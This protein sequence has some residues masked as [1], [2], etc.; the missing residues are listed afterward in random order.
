MSQCV[1]LMGC[2]S[3]KVTNSYKSDDDDDDDD[4][5]DNFSEDEDE[6]DIKS[7]SDLMASSQEGLEGYRVHWDDEVSEEYTLPGFSSRPTTGRSAP[8]GVRRY[9][10][11]A[12]SG[13]SEY[14]L[15]E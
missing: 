8:S 13:L 12:V 15:E 9:S 6:S 2:L 10:R 3:S 4:D 7:G 11:G 1:D 5:D 14:V